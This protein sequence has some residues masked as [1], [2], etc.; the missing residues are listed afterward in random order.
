MRADLLTAR[1]VAAPLDAAAY[2]VL[3]GIAI[4]ALLTF[5]DYGLSWDDY[6]QAH[7][8]EMLLAFY[9]SGFADRSAFGFYNLRYYGGGFDLVA[10]IFNKITPFDLFETR[11]LLGAIVGLAGL[12]VTWRLARRLGGPLA[13]LMALALLATTPLWYGHMFINSKDTP[14]AVAMIFLL[15]TL[16]RAFE[17]YPRPQLRTMVLFGVALGLTLGTRVIGGVAVVFAA[18]GALTMLAI[19]ARALGFKS[20]A[21]RLALFT[22][23]LALALPLAYVV[24]GAIW[25]WGVLAPLNPFRALE[26]YSNFWEK[27]WRELFEGARIWIPDMPRSYVPQLC[28]MKLPEILVALALAG[29]VGGTAAAIR[30]GI[31]PWRRASFALLVAAAVAPIAIAVVTRPVLYNGI[32][33]FIFIV[34]P[35][36]VLAGVAAAYIFERL[37]ARALPAAVASAAVAVSLI[38]ISVIDFVRVHP[39]QYALFNHASGGIRGARDRYMLDYWGLGLKE[40]SEALLVRLEEMHIDPP[41]DR[42]WRVAVCGPAVV[43]G[44]ELG[45]SFEVTNDAKG[46]DFAIT[47]GTY[48]CAKLNTAVLAVAERDGVVFARAYDVRG[49][50]IASAYAPPDDIDSANIE[51]DNIL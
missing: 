30:G 4:T 36:A 21:T 43:V 44:F 45:P 39:Y 41:R 3:L 50:T 10:S 33:H 19:E 7:Y 46:A 29:T 25:P 12:A 40:V 6:S 2:V 26:Y 27:P 31:E 32:R 16:V 47:L 28:L 8:G 1:L 42:K 11:R 49:R 51:L 5:R 35:L 22:V 38:G 14:F 17:E 37:Y 23:S 48:Y 9:T 34:P 15:F 24:M 18:A 13:G 20:A